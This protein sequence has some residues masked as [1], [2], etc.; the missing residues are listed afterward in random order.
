MALVGQRVA[1]ENELR[2]AGWEVTQSGSSFLPVSPTQPTF[3]E[4]ERGPGLHPELPSL[5]LGHLAAWGRAEPNLDAAR[6]GRVP[7]RARGGVPL[8]TGMETLALG[9]APTHLARE[10]VARTAGRGAQG[11]FAIPGGSG[12]GGRARHVPGREVS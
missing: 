9:A 6:E 1:G 3:L 4:A 7:E 2:S 5:A 12:G 10:I 11:A 8:R